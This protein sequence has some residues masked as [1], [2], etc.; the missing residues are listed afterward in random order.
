MSYHVAREL[1]LDKDDITSFEDLRSL[2]LVGLEMTLP[3]SVF[4]RIHFHY[5]G[6]DAMSWEW[7]EG[8]CFAS[9]GMKRTGII[10]EYSCGVMYRIECWLRS[11]SVGCETDPVIT[12][13]LMHETG[14][15]HGE[16]RISGF[17]L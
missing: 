2:M 6:R 5:P 17:G 1:G 16:I 8:E 14:A 11:M 10:D 4:S 9:K 15:C 12:G 3:H 13:Y 7:E